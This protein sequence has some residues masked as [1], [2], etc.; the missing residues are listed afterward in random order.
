MSLDLTIP[1]DDGTPG[2]SVPVGVD[3]HGRLMAIAMQMQLEILARLADYYEDA[4][5]APNELAALGQACARIY[6]ECREDPE[7]ATLAARIGRLAKLANDSRCA[8]W[9]IAD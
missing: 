4:E 3:Q 1:R 2:E 9:A 8:V 7:I 6:E 5:F